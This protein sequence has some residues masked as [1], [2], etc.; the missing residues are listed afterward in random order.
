MRSLQEAQSKYTL[1]GQ[2]A[3]ANNAMTGENNKVYNDMLRK[4]GND[5]NAKTQLQAAKAAK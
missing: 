2:V 1:A 5:V 3:N 4:Y